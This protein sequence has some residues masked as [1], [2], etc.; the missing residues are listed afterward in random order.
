MWEAGHND[1]ELMKLIVNMLRAYVVDYASAIPEVKDIVSE[2][3]KSQEFS[4]LISKVGPKVNGEKFA[5]L[6]FRNSHNRF[7]KY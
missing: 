5:S 2:M 4:E 6:E 3:K 7:L 1:P